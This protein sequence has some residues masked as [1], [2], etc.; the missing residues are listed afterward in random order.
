[1]PGNR[2]NISV[3]I[4]KV[5]SILASQFHQHEIKYMLVAGSPSDCTVLSER[6][7]MWTF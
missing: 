6:P 2:D 5:I 3:E 7:R 1:M 4:L